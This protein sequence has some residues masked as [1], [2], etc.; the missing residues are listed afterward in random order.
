MHRLAPPLQEMNVSLLEG[1]FGSGAG[2]KAEV[3]VNMESRKMYGY[4]GICISNLATVFGT[5][6]CLSVATG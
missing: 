3:P 4:F 5:L 2:Q 1:D 6:Y